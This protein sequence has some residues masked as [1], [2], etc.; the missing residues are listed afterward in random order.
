[1][2]KNIKIRTVD[3]YP[4]FLTSNRREIEAGFIFSLWK[5]PESYGDFETEIDPVRDF[6]TNEG[7]FYYALG[8]GMYKKNYRSFDDASIYTYLTDKPALEKAYEQRGGYLTV[9]ELM[10]VV[11]VANQES[12]YDELLKSNALMQLH[13]EGYA[14]EKH[15]ELFKN[16]SYKDLE[17]FMEYKLNNIFLKS[18][19]SGISVTDLTS[20]YE[21]WIKKW[22][23]GE[24]I[25]FRVGF[26]LLNY[27]LAGVHKNNLILHLGN[28][29]NG[30]TTSALLMYVL[31]ILESGER[32]VIIGN[33][34]DEEQFRQMVLATVLF[35]RINY[36]KMNRQ[37]LLFGNFT[38][39]DEQ[40]LNEA[41]KWLEK[42]E[43]NLIFVHLTD[44]GT[45][46][47]KRIIKK[48]SKLGVEVFLFDTLKPVDESSEKAWAEFSETAKMLFQLAQKEQIAIIATAQL[49]SESAKRR[50][51]D[52][53]CI[54]KSRAI[55]E[56]AGQVIMFRTM[57]EAEKRELFV[58]TFMRDEKGKYTKVKKQITLD[59]NKDYIIVFIP[60]N[61]YGSSEMQIVY[62]RNMN[63]NYYKELGYCQIEYDG[64]GK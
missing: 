33:E 56:T 17:D 44:Y 59:E 47:V 49:S 36:R 52:L 53:S 63:F 21:K 2:S 28:I 64:F 4:S 25:G 46:N 42:F 37:K 45:A 51:L 50:F 27:H 12:Y 43:K 40:H 13:D 57:R 62:E 26:S 18:A 7:I 34:Q 54:G 60:K 14:L 10:S 30:K 6:R 58:Y 11:H 16:M 38:E 29:G 39:E 41:A 8:L 55:A 19:S 5:N 9:V 32:I 1:M 15:M 20:G 31:P 35:N 22:N 48:Y 23:S 3:D 61:R 24:G